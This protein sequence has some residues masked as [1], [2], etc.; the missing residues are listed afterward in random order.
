MHIE[1]AALVC[2]GELVKGTGLGD[3]L[4]SAGLKTIGLQT[5]ICDVNDIKKAR[6]AT[7]VV[8]PVLYA[9]LNDAYNEANNCSLSY[10]EWVREQNNPSFNYWWLILEHQKNTNLLIISLREA[11]FT[12][13]ISALDKLCPLF[14]SLDHVHYARWISVFVHDLIKMLKVKNEGLFEQ[15]MAGSFTVMK[16]KSMFCKMAFDQCHEQNN[17]L[18]KSK[19]GIIDLL[20]REDTEFLKKLELVSPEIQHYL[21]DIENPNERQE[22]PHKESSQT[23]VEKFIGDCKSVYSMFTTNPFLETQLQKLNTTMF[24]QECIVKD[25]EKL[26]SIGKEQYENFKLTRFVLGSADVI[27]TTI[28]KNSLK[29]PSN[30]SKLQVESHQIKLMPSTVIKLRN[31]CTYRESLAKDIFKSEFTGNENLELY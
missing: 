14:F 25:T 28:Q 3:I 8:A 30:A 31:S 11:N 15:F 16:S 2:H 22:R 21:D 12:L 10:E 1:Q 7:Q 20:N 19:S 6:Y 23:F 4:T 29:L 18:I 26:G 27:K 9:L 5:A 24:F 17:K 13:F